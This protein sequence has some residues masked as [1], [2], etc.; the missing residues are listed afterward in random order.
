MCV[1]Y[2]ICNNSKN[3]LNLENTLL[4]TVVD[5]IRLSKIIYSKLGTI[6][7]KIKVQT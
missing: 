2:N 4:N 6:S 3:H 7:L 1:V 5:D